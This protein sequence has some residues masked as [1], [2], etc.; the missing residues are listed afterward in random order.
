VKADDLVSFGTATVVVLTVALLATYLP[1]R[2]AVAVDPAV[3]L[4][5]E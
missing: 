4:R 3:T 1:A 5:A 2:S